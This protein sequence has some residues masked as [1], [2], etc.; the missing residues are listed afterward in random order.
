MFRRNTRSRR[1]SG[2]S[3]RSG[4]APGSHR[5]FPRGKGRRIFRIRNTEDCIQLAREAHSTANRF[6]NSGRAADL[7]RPARM[8]AVPRFGE[9]IDQPL[10]LLIKIRRH[11]AVDEC[12][13]DRSHDFHERTRPRLQ[14]NVAVPGHAQ[15]L[16]NSGKLLRVYCLADVGDLAHQR[17][18][19]RGDPAAIRSPAARHPATGVLAISMRLD[20]C[21]HG[22][23]RV[24]QRSHAGIRLGHWMIG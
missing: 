6:P 21:N 5:A 3:R 7:F 9:V 22:S 12:R 18:Q 23:D 20:F 15:L 11:H 8:L 10:Q 14:G 16:R 2:D 4:I 24:L 17:A 13:F 1:R 19:L